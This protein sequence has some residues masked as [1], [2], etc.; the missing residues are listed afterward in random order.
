MIELKQV[1]R[2][3]LES[4]FRA[5]YCLLKSERVRV[6]QVKW[7]IGELVKDIK[8]NEIKARLKA[9]IHFID[10]KPENVEA[11]PELIVRSDFLKGYCV[12]IGVAILLILAGH[13][14]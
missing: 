2:R 3:A 11:E 9:L 6:E 8:D 5:N 14:Y 4:S 10:L 12:G 1:N 13:L 7:R